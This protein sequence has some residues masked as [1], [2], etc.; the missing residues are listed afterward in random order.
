MAV[1]KLVNVKGDL[2]ATTFSFVT[3]AGIRLVSSVVLTRVLLPEAYGIITVLVSVLYVTGNII[4]TNVMLFIVRD[5]NAEQ[6]RYL[7]TAWTL[8]FGRCVLNG[9]FL[10]ASA[11]V[12]A[13]DIYNLPNLTLP[14]RVFAL[15]FLFD[16]FESMSFPLAIR[17]KQARLLVYSELG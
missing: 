8:R 13:V 6:P 2:F 14:L 10:L 15:W 7:N 5:K 9:L 16:A 11:R 17:R 3:Q 12:I 1:S 4:D